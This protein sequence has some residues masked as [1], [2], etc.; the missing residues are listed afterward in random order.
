V[1]NAIPHPGFYVIR[2]QDL[3]GSF[4]QSLEVTQRNCG[5]SSLGILRNV[6]IID[7]RRL[8]TN[9]RYPDFKPNNTWEALWVED[10]R[11]SPWVAADIAAKAAYIVQFNIFGCNRNLTKHVK[12]GQLEKGMQLFQQM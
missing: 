4:L 3:A 10:R 9:E 5:R 8:W 12:F 6:G 1:Q 7:Q 11:N 2:V